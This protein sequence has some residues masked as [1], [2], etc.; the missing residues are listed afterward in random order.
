MP[1]DI[2]QSNPATCSRVAASVSVLS[3]TGAADEIGSGEGRGFT[4]NVPL[5]VGAVDE[6]YRLAFSSVVVPVP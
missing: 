1:Q 4:V 2:F 3:G 5:E 6:D